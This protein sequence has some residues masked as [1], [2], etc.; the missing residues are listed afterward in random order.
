MSAK[1]IE[2]VEETNWKCALHRWNLR[3]EM[4]R[5]IYFRAFLRCNEI[6]ILRCR[7]INGLL[8]DQVKDYFILTVELISITKRV[9]ML[10]LVGNSPSKSHLLDKTDKKLISS[11]FLAGDRLQQ[12]LDQPT[13]A[14][15][16]VSPVLWVRL[17]L[18]LQFLLALTASTNGLVLP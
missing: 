3:L 7:K 12:L 1:N 4:S 17:C 13:S 18:W 6:I 10:L 8:M 5:K 11:H 9:Q 2:N 15:T 16:L 14:T